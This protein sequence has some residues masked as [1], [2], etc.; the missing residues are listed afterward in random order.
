MNDLQQSELR[1]GNLS[2]KFLDKEHDRAEV[3]QNVLTQMSELHAQLYVAVG[4]IDSGALLEG[5][6]QADDML[7]TQL[8]TKTQ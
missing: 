8:V 5:D 6:P 7:D 3:A 2:G 1:L 4:S